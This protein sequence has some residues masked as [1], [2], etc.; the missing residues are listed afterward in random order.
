MIDEEAILEI[1]RRK[2]L[3]NYYYDNFRKYYEAKNFSKASEFLWGALNELSYAIGMFYGRKLGDHGKVV[4][5][6]RELAE[7]NRDKEMGEFMDAA[8]SI[9]ANF[10]HDF[11]DELVFETNKQKT[12]KLLEKL[13]KILDS[14]LKKLK[15]FT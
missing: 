2:E 6:V 10:F 9:H 11:M 13:T 1:K 15:R 5:F 4:N 7:I 12:E 8:Q 14:E 3:A